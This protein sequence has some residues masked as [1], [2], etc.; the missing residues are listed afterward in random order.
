MSKPFVDYDEERRRVDPKKPG[1]TFRLC[2]QDFACLPALP[3][4]TLIAMA[5]AIRLDQRGRQVF[6]APDVIGFIHDALREREW[7]DWQ[8][9][10]DEDDVMPSDLTEEQRTSIT[11]NGG[12]W[13]PADDRQ[14]FQRICDGT[15]DIVELELLVK[16]MGDISEFYG[17][18]PTR[19][20]KR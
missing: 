13:E 4:A 11:D 14:R 5:Q 10:P 17:E 3:G 19:R 8:F 9:V 16:I 7:I 18:R 2:D 15:E 6:N 1:F 20:S 12:Y